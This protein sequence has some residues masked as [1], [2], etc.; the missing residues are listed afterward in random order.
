MVLESILNPEQIEKRPIEMIIFGFIAIDLRI[1]YLNHLILKY[2]TEAN[3]NTEI[4]AN[5]IY[6]NLFMMIGI[7]ICFF[8]IIGIVE[9]K[10]RTNAQ[11]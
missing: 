6:P 10:K 7:I 1:I 11:Q 5:M 2:L 4:N 9:F 8:S 3:Y